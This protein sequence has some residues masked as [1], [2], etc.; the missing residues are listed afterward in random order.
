MYPLCKFILNAIVIRKNTEDWIMNCLKYVLVS[1]VMLMLLAGGASAATFVINSGDAALSLA[2][3]PDQEVAF[4][5]IAA[6]DPVSYSATMTAD[7]SSGA[8][9]MQE[10]SVEDAE[11]VFSVSAAI[12]PDGDSAYTYSKLWSGSAITTQEA[13]VNRGS[14]VS[15][16]QQTSHEGVAGGSVIAATDQDGNTASQVAAFIA[17]VL[18]TN[19]TAETLASANAVQEGD[20]SGLGAITIGYARAVDGDISLTGSGLYNGDLNTNQ[21]MDTITS[22]NA[23]QTGDFTGLGAIPFGF[24]RVVEGDISPTGPGLMYG[25]MTFDNAATAVDTTTTASQDV[26][27][28]GLLGVALSGSMDQN[29]NIASQNA[30]FIDQNGNIASQNTGFIGGVLH[31]NQITDTTASANAMQQGDFSGSDDSVAMTIGFARA[32]DGD[33]SYSVAGV[34]TEGVGVMSFDDQ[35]TAQD[36]TTLSGQIV[37]LLAPTGYGYAATG[38]DDGKNATRSGSE[39]YG[40]N[41]TM[42]QETDT[43]ASAHTVQDGTL[44]AV[45][46]ST[47]GEAEF[48]NNRRSWTSSSVSDGTITLNNNEMYADSH[49]TGTQDLEIFGYQGEAWVGSTHRENYAEAGVMFNGSSPLTSGFLDMHQLTDA[50]SSA[51]TEQC[52]SV[53]TLN[54]TPGGASTRT[55]AGNS[56]GRQ[57]FV[58]TLG[59]QT[60]MNVIESTALSNDAKSTVFEN[61]TRSAGSPSSTT[62]AYATNGIDTGTDTFSGS[63]LGTKGHAKVVSDIPTANVNGYNP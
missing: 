20:F 58:A 31:T 6:K 52:G 45:S 41:L 15:V 23:V 21:I 49:T 33:T 7:D 59:R 22:A 42:T 2:A 51:S 54:S 36:T 27:M 34:L 40:G 28:D 35:A 37:E 53:G 5:F 55:E 11:Y 44:T 12:S 1:S 57:A 39:L 17:G 56:S 9:A 14:I 48:K 19:Q 10:T 3:T 30:G 50:A 24:A 8:G 32:A 62:I 46:G 18:H 61:K 4:S 38:S 25:Q 43:S 13:R 16:G 63:R 26:R 47:W 60:T 29:G